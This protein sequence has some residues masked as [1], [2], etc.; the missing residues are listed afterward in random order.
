M[1]GYLG[2]ER[3]Y[4]V[5]IAPIIWLICFK[6]LKREVKVRRTNEAVAFDKKLSWD[7]LII[8]IKI[9]GYY[10]ALCLIPF[11]LTWYH[12]FMQSG[13]GGGNALERKKALSL[14]WPFWVGITVLGYVIYS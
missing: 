4:L 9:Y 7:K 2:S 12:S 14:N 13:A 11:K 10:F 8:S 1:L 5:L 6:R 3:F